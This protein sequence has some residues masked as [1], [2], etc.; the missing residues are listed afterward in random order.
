MR[1]PSERMFD[2]GPKYEIMRDGDRSNSLTRCRFRSRDPGGTMVAA[3]S[4]TDTCFF[5]ESIIGPAFS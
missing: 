4:H 5:I 2:M 3:Q 1:R